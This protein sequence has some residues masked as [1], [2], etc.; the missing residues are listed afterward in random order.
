MNRLVIALTLLF[1]PKLAHAGRIKVAVV[2]GIAVN[3]DA[4]RVDALSQ[5]LA[6]ALVAE[7]DL[8]AVGGLEV[9]RQLPPEGLP[10]DCVSTPSCTADVARR[11]GANQ[12]LF[13]VM[14]DSGGAVQI[15]TTWIDVATGNQAS[16]PAIDLTSTADLDARGKF[17]T[18]ATQLLPD[19]PVRP[20][21]RTGLTLDTRMT[22]ATPRHFAVPSYLTTGV[23]AIGLGV[24]IGFGLET[25]SKYNT[26][27]GNPN[28]C[29]SSQRSTIR[30]D[31]L[32]ADSGF[33]IAT[34]A[35]IAT[36]VLYATSGESPHVIV[37]PT[38]EGVGV[39]AFGRF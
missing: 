21:P 7:L 33:L 10:P 9:R 38:P 6:E 26:C 5:D 22:A 15:D 39:A 32:I 36:V 37:N 20:K 28:A 1:V 30:S 4:A 14:V 18:V 8:E 31:G 19:A 34:G 13:V 17:Q 25:R 3:L 2:P 23:A 27:N 24:G 11:T 12:L 29:T 16:R 35:A